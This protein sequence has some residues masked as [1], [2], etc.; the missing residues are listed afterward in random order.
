MGIIDQ[1]IITIKCPTCSNV[2]EGKFVDKGSPWS[3]SSWSN[4]TNFQNF[5]VTWNDTTGTSPASVA[6][7]TCVECATEA[8]VSS[9]FKV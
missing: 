9:S 6:K 2:E 5:N 8:E 3:G 7:A 1:F 4:R